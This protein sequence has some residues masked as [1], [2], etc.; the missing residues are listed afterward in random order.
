MSLRSLYI[1]FQGR[2]EGRKLNNAARLFDLESPNELHGTCVQ[3]K[4]ERDNVAYLHKR[5][6]N[7]EWF[8][9]PCYVSTFEFRR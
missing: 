6:G 2:Y 9:K 7:Q 8:C 1:D 5:S 4:T 3:C